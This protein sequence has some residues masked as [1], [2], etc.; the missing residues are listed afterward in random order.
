MI[1][2]QRGNSAAVR[3]PAPVLAAAHLSTGQV[4]DMRAEPKRIIIEPIRRVKVDLDALIA[5]ITDANRYEVLNVGAPLGRET[6]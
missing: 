4:V 2:R 3:I 1:V 6:W 5:G